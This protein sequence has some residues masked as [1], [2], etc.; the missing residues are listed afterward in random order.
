[1]S[2]TQNSSLWEI[3]I[4]H[5]EPARDHETS[6]LMTEMERLK[7][8]S[9]QSIESRRSF[10]LEGELT[11]AQ[12]H[13]AAAL[14]VDPVVEAYELISQPAANAEA[15]QPTTNVL[16]KPGV[17]D[18]VAL[19]THK[20]LSHEGFDVQSVST[21]R[22]FLF[23]NSAEANE[24]QEFAQAV[25]FNQ[26]I[27]RVLPGKLQLQSIAIG[28]DY[29]LEIKSLPLSGLSDDQLVAL[30]DSMM[31]SLSL[32][33][34]QTIRDHFATLDREPTDIELETIAQTWSEHCSHKT[35]AGRI[36]Y[37]SEGQVQ[38]YENML[39][40]TIFKATQAL[41]ARW[42]EDDWCVSVF[43]DNAGVV[44]FNDNFHACIKVETH[45]RPSAI[46]PYGG[47]NTGLGGVIRDCLGTGLGGRP[48]ANLDVFCFAPLETPDDQL[49][50]GILPPRTIARNVVAGVRDYGNRM[51]IPT[52][53]G[54]VHFDERYL[55][56]PL[57]YCGTVA[58]MPHEDAMKG[59]PQP[60]NLIVAVGGRTGL[61]GIHGATFSSAGLNE[62]SETLAAGA[63]QIGNAI[64][65][66]MVTEAVLRATKEKLFNAVTDCGAGGF[67]SAIGEMGEEIGA[68]VWLD[69]CPLKYSGLNYTEIWISE[70]QERMVL[71]VPEE[72]WDRF[73]EI[74]ESEGV[75]A[76]IIGQFRDDQQ[77]VL[78]YD[79]Q[80]VGSL[81]MELLHD[82]RPPIIREATFTPPQETP[83]AISL[84]D[85]TETLCQLLAS[86]DIASKEWIIR[87]YDHEVQAGS[88]VKPLQGITYDGPGDAAVV[89][90]D[91][92]SERGLVLSNGMHP[93]YG[94]IDSYWMTASAID[95]A[96]R[97]AIAVGANPSRIAVLDNFCWANTDD[98]ETLGALVRSAIA[99]HDAALEF[100][101]PFVSGK[102]SLH[103][104][105]RYQDNGEQKTVSI[106]H[107]LLI[108]AMGQIDDLNCAMTMDLKQ[109]GSHLLLVGETKQELGG[110][111]L[112]SLQNLSGG[113]VPKVDFAKAKIVHQAV[114]NVIAQQ[115][116]LAV[117]DLSDGGLAVGAAEMAFSGALGLSLKLDALSEQSGL[118]DPT[119]LLFSESNTR[120]LIEVAPDQLEA[121]QQTL[122]DA[123]TVLLGEVTQSPELTISLNEQTLVSADIATLKSHWQNG[124]AWE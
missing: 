43:D 18:N 121:V 36:R 2:V 50:E 73:R 25:L 84:E 10:L 104:V 103:N 118:T 116:A 33:E 115:Q 23:N 9:L 21:C 122:Q 45:N 61:D 65:E 14:V 120:Y 4:R 31:L 119:A 114:A 60:G 42:G 66:K 108:S 71:S 40:E 86:P 12:A 32:V 38:Q 28:S 29:E 93:R 19:T 90:P 67:S 72:H 6:R 82:G 117:H 97:N 96:I 111:Q 20:E 49:P 76:N 26:A 98:P 105:F 30:S 89:Q 80:T 46:E 87:Q 91:L 57:V 124:I 58:V 102:D 37:T 1:M 92:E 8:N 59:V 16:Y 85:C 74:C 107:S 44:T 3:E 5:L 110:S 79:D 48:V 68:E 13:Q 7:L 113:V 22:K 17:T 55:G 41:R 81:S 94:D 109:V 54:A 106:P 56:N 99:C 70:A 112:A 52:V 78:K 83:L 51:G 95:E 75:E 69:R 88:I 64:T 11:E 53:N 77:L 35:L 34:M 101:T 15:S 39:K 62:Q 27:E 24:V 47:A 123:P 63:V 100:E